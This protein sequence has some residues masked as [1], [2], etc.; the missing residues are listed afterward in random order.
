MRPKSLAAPKITEKLFMQRI[1]QAARAL[2]FLVY[3]TFNAYRSAKGFPDLTMVHRKSGRLIFVEVK[4]EDGK[5]TPEQT[6]WI[7]TLATTGGEV[8]VVKPSDWDRWFWER[9]KR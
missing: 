1:I 4:S 9:L 7:N 8:Y 3:H 6:Q 2:G 5:L